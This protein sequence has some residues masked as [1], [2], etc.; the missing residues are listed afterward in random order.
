ML[1]ISRGIRNKNPGNLI[2]TNITWLGKI[3]QKFSTDSHFEQFETMEHGIRAMLID[4]IHDIKGGKNTV[5]KLITAY[6]PPFENN[7]QSYIKDVSLALG[8]SSDAKITLINHKFMML[9]SRAIIR[10]ENGKDS[11]KVSDG[12]IKKAITMLGDV[13]SNLLEVNVSSGVIIDS[14]IISAF[15]LFYSVLAYTL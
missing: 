7:T 1:P 6:A 2:R 5:Q 13:S 9:L 14:V 8:I 12:Q 10:K 4:V 3:D 15:L 11:N